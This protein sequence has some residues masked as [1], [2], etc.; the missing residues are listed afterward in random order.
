[1]KVLE[2]TFVPKLRIKRIWGSLI[3]SYETGIFKLIWKIQECRA[4]YFIL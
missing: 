4:G 2:S 3:E 1:M